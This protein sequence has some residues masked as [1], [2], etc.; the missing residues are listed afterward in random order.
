MVRSRGTHLTESGCEKRFWTSS[1][2]AG[3]LITHN[4]SMHHVCPQ[5]DKSF[6]KESERP[7]Q[8]RFCEADFK[9][10]SSGLNQERGLERPSVCWVCQFSFTNDQIGSICSTLQ[11]ASTKR[12]QSPLPPQPPCRGVS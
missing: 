12:F 11:F 8:C 2:L 5:C 9:R 7:Y 3:H 4:P 1:T 10:E 6:Y